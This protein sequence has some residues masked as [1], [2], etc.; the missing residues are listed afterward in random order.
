MQARI[1]GFSLIE[2]MVVIAVVGIIAA[3][4]MPSYQQ[5]I[6]KTRRVDAK[7]ELTRLAALEEQFYA[8]KNQY[9]DNLNDVLNVAAGTYG[10]YVTANG[11]YYSITLSKPNGS[12]ERYLITAQAQGA[13]LKDDN[14]EKLTLDNFGEKLSY[15]DNN[16]ASTGCW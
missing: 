10:T 12:N 13:Q 5:H 3:I 15:D 9:S 6:Q 14:C 2:L 16:A 4:A 8:R 11:G 7:T 1:S